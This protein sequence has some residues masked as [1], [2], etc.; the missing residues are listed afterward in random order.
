LTDHDIVRLML[1]SFTVTKPHLVNLIRENPRYTKM[2]PE[3][4]LGKFVSRRMMVK[5]ARYVDDIANGPLPRYE[6]QPVALK[7][8]NSQEALPNKVAQVE[9]ARLNE[10]E[11]VLVIKRFKNTL[12]GRPKQEQVKGKALLLQ[13]L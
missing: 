1:R 2:T 7:E 8:T 10:D 6:P 4:N 9:A 13:M 12:K 3:E 5:E 11:M